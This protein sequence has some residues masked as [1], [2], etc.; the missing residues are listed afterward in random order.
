MDDLI[1]S[2][3]TGDAYRT[4]RNRK[5]ALLTSIKETRSQEM[6]TS[7]QETRSQEMQ[8]GDLDAEKLLEQ[9]QV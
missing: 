4:K 5:S 9:I 3:K 7:I 2:L 1:S 8:G 6:P